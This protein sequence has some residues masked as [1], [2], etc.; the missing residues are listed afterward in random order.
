PEVI[1]ATAHLSVMLG[2][3]MDRIWPQIGTSLSISESFSK[4]DGLAQFKLNSNYYDLFD[5]ADLLVRKSM[6]KDVDDAVNDLKTAIRATIVAEY[7][8]RAHR[9]AYGMTVYFPEDEELYVYYGDQY[10][11]S[12]KFASEVG[13]EE[14]LHSYIEAEQSDTIA[15]TIEITSISP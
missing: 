6:D 10:S 7:H 15:P 12:S 4:S 13:W 3:R 2:E 1:N 11:G 9:F 8:G 5:F 14:F